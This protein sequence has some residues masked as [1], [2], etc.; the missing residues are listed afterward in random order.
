MSSL[1]EQRRRVLLLRRQVQMTVPASTSL[2]REFWQY[3]FAPS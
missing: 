1:E 3:A 2:M